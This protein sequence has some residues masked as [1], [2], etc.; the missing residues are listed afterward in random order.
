MLGDDIK[1][2]QEKFSF[3]HFSKSNNI[4]SSVIERD[5]IQPLFENIDNIDNI[6]LEKSKQ[7]LEWQDYR[8]NYVKND[9]A[10]IMNHSLNHYNMSTFSRAKVFE[11]IQISTKKLKKEL[12][13]IPK[14]FAVPFG[15]VTGNL[16]V[17]LNNA[18]WHEDYKGVLWVTNGANI[19]VDKMKSQILHL[20]RIHVPENFLMFLKTLIFALKRTHRSITNYVDTKTVSKN[21]KLHVNSGNKPDPALSA[22]NLLRYGKDYASD[23]SY[24]NYSFSQNI[25]RTKRPDYYFI[26]DSERLESIGYN[27][28]TRFKLLGKRYDG[29]YWSGWRKLPFTAGNVNAMLLLK[30]MQNESII[31]SYKPNQEVQKAFQSSYWKKIL[32]QEKRHLN[33]LWRKS[34]NYLQV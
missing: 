3:Y 28:H 9:Y 29:I 32:L 15:T 24:Y 26:G 12:D 25:F 20:S 17:D 7:Y 33:H 34:T 13:I 4:E 16:L 10:T 22:E 2:D 30:A 31:G 27:F 19:A 6:L 5:V 14:Y 21:K 23:S 11:E 18:A 8:N 1:I